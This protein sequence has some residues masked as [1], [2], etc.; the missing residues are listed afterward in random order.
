[1]W[2]VMPDAVSV[3]DLLAHQ[4][5]AGSFELDG[6]RAIDTCYFSLHAEIEQELK[7]LT[8]GAIAT[9]PREVLV[10]AAALLTMQKH[11][12][13]ESALWDRAHAKGRRWLANQLGASPRDV[14]TT[15][16][17]LAKKLQRLSS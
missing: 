16:D 1:V 3:R 5:A 13:S 12:A 11:Y 9:I 4:T 15:L 17:G 7:V 2:I 8:G 10:T 6:D 14:K